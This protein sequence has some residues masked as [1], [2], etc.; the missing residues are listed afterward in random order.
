MSEP[1]TKDEL[2]G[3]L[4]K[5]FA[6]YQAA[7]IEAVDFKF[8]KIDSRITGFEEKLENLVVSLDTVLKKYSEYEEKMGAL[9]SEVE[10]IKTVIQKQ[11]GIELG[12]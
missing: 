9:R 7:I 8:Q 11:L 6:Q 3:I 4:D 1:I 12:F 5:K 10:K 2:E